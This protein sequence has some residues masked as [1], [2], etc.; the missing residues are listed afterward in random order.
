M[1][2]QAWWVIEL[3][4]ELECGPGWARVPVRKVR[5]LRLGRGGEGGPN[6]RGAPRWF[7][8]GFDDPPRPRRRH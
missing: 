4:E 1:E 8:D 3:E 2:Q 6:R 5:R 7:E